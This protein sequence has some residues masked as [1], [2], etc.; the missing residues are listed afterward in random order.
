M[1]A[2]KH[3]WSRDGYWAMVGMEICRMCAKVRR[4]KR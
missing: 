2:C 3:R 4:V 1:T